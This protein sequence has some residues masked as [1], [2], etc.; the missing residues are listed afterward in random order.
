MHI[1]ILEHRPH[2]PLHI[3]PC[4]SVRPCFVLTGV[5]WK[6]IRDPEKLGIRPGLALPMG[7]GHVDEA[8]EEWACEVEIGTKDEGIFRLSEL[9]AASAKWT[10]STWDWHNDQPQAPCGHS[11]SSEVRGAFHV[12]RCPWGNPMGILL[13][14]VEQQQRAGE[15]SLLR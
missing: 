6:W 11:P 10:C 9:G 14:A 1:S 12:V 15:E 8:M 7:T 4:P 5:R 13:P 2:Q 3:I